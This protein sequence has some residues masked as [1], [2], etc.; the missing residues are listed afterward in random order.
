MTHPITPGGRYALA[1]F[2]TL[3]TT[4]VAIFLFTLVKCDIT[5]V[6]P[7]LLRQG[8][9]LRC[10]ADALWVL[11]PCIFVRTDVA[12]RYAIAAMLL[13]ALWGFA[14][15][16]YFKAYS[17]LMPFSSLLLWENVSP[18]LI[19]SFIGLLRPSDMLFAALPL[20]AIAAL[21]FAGSRPATF[22]RAT[23]RAYI[24]TLAATTVGG[25]AAN[26]ID[27]HLTAQVAEADGFMQRTVANRYKVSFRRFNYVCLN[28]YLPYVAY[29]IFDSAR[30][31]LPPSPEEMDGITKFL[32]SSQP[33]YTDNSLAADSASQK[34]LIFIIVESLNAW[35]V[36]MEIDGRKVCP[37]L[38]HYAHADS[39]IAMLHVC[40]QV[41]HGHSSD[42]RL[43]YNTGLLPMQN[44]IAATDRGHNHYP[45]LAHALGYRAIDIV[46]DSKASWNQEATSA[47]YGFD[48][49][50][51]QSTMLHLL[52]DN[53][54]AD[55]R[56]FAK[57]T[58]LITPSRRA[59]G[60]FMALITSLT[61]HQPYNTPGVPTTWISQK[62]K[63]PTEVLNYL[64]RTHYFDTELGKFLAHLERTGLLRNSVV[65]IASDHNDI[66][67]STLRGDSHTTAADKEIVCLILGY[68]RRV[69]IERTV[70]Q[71]DIYPTV[72][73]VMG[74]NAYHWKGL[75]NSVLR[76]P[77]V[78]SAVTFAGSVVGNAASPLA[79][80]QRKA[81]Q[82]SNSIIKHNYF[83]TA[84]SNAHQ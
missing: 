47:A 1:F 25:F 36:D 24:A 42:G 73:D 59:D 14:Q 29:Q 48:S 70:G 64:E 7:G 63:Y 31:A 20:A 37:T 54:V 81:W 17:D 83:A 15:E 39:V 10:L 38:S 28:G 9:A 60:P 52:P 80:R 51:D 62:G 34:N 32:H 16:V 6:A 57:A 45:S 55:A 72:L 12:G 18:L 71:I 58:E 76:E 56:I 26:A 30:E 77:Q 79:T 5:Y 27:Y 69:S 46:G 68:N 35:A 21:H 75:G 49:I 19:D 78:E 66:P 43:I 82:I 23:K 67:A 74:A 8:I 61:M 3:A 40:T 84:S 2:G 41:A 22:S 13:C 44:A 11:L 33:T 50:F 53:A 65:V 4:L